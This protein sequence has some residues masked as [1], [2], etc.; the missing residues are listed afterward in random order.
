[1]KTKK[2][3]NLRNKISAPV[4]VASTVFAT[5]ASLASCSTTGGNDSDKEISEP[6]PSAAVD[7]AQIPMYY[8]DLSGSLNKDFLLCKD[9]NG[10]DININLNFSRLGFTYF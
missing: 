2:T 10:T 5:A 8:F 4:L 6:T 3:H 9:E 1:M 7:F